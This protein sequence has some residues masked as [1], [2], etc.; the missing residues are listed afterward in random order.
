M[1]FGILINCQYLV[2]KLAILNFLKCPLI[3]Y[4]L[5]SCPAVIGWAEL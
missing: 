2:L 3:H 5:L 4:K 1:I